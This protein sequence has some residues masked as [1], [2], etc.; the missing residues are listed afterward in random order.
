[1]DPCPVD[2]GVGSLVREATGPVS[3]AEGPDAL[4][5]VAD[6]EACEPDSV[7]VGEP[8]SEPEA[9][10]VTPVE[11]ET[12]PDA[13]SVGPAEPETEP[14]AV[15]VGPV[16]PD[17]GPDGVAV[18]VSLTPGDVVVPDIGGTEAD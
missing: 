3:D 16:E 2:P 10:P 6:P 1:M 5:P 8:D 12:E 18:A 7:L 9:V 14:D 15:S 11:P 17:T 4:E 13:V